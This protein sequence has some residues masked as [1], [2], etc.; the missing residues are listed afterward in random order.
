[1]EL[2]ESLVGQNN[3]GK[4]KHSGRP[5]TPDVKAETKLHGYKTKYSHI[6]TRWTGQNRKH[7]AKCCKSV[8]SEDTF[9]SGGMWNSTDSFRRQVGSDLGDKIDLSHH[10][11]ITFLGVYSRELKLC[12]HKMLNTSVYHQLQLLQQVSDILWYRQETRPWW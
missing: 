7:N 4:D 2:Q 6:D 3:L 11:V 8:R 9:F 1:M 12:P 10:L 5:H